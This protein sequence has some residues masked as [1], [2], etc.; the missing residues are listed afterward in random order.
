MEITIT[1]PEKVV[2]ETVEEYILA[3]KLDY[4]LYFRVHGFPRELKQGD[5]V[6]FITR[7]R[8]I[9]YHIFDRCEEVYE[10]WVC[11][12]R[13]ETWKAGKYIVRKGDSL[14]FLKYPITMKSHRGF[15][16]VRSDD[17]WREQIVE[18]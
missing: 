18:K 8:I 15:K 10:D 13:G 14:R 2:K 11:L 12:I 3:K 1:I 6:F 16:Y 5:R 4:E 9:G 17:K 7:G